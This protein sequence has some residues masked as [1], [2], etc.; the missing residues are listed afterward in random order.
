MSQHSD[1]RPAAHS[2][3][4]RKT[5]NQGNKQKNWKEE[6]LK[7]A[8]GRGNADDQLVVTRNLEVRLHHQNHRLH[9]G[10]AALDD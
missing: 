8:H 2:T 3:G 5:Q 9:L 6:S 1:P 4:T 10:S 7:I